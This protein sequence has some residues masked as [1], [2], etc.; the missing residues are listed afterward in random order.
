M[1]NTTSICSHESRLPRGKPV[2][3]ERFIVGER[4][5]RCEHCEPVHSEPTSTSDTRAVATGFVDPL[6][7]RNTETNAKGKIYAVVFS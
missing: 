4:P 2:E 5:I 1:R 3:D 7:K 6:E